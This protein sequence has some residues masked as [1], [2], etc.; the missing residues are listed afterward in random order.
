VRHTC[1]AVLA[2]AAL[3]LGACGGGGDD[4][5]SAPPP[6]GGA[7]TREDYIARADAFCKRVNAQAKGLNGRMRD[8]ARGAS[9]PGAQLAAIVPI[10][11]EGY[12]MQRRSRDEFKRIPY[13]PADRGIVERLYA[14]FDT[15]TELV[16]QLLRASEARDV[17]RVRALTREQNRV[18]LQARGLAQGYGFKECG[19]GRN[20]AS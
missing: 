13:P 18:K 14:A 8:A 15:Q 10:L 2:G 11:E 16:G 4:S 9:S 19:S 7:V 12:R 6:D 3:L 5:G 20:E 1:A 17:G